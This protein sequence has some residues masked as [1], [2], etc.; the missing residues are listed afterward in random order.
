VQAPASPNFRAPR[1]SSTFAEKRQV[2]SA[3]ACAVP[4]RV[5]TS[6]PAPH[7]PQPNPSALCRAPVSRSDRS[8]RG[9][10]PTARVPA[11]AKCWPVARRAEEICGASLPV[12]PTHALVLRDS[13]RSDSGGQR[14]G[15]SV[16]SPPRSGR[17]FAPGFALRLAHGRPSVGRLGISRE[18][19]GSDCRSVLAAACRRLLISAGSRATR[20]MRSCWTSARS[21]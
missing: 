7:E 14:A 19:M 12:A 8:H 2:R 21:W 17:L 11:S 1:A 15:P 3:R 5:P 13:R 10:G 18:A 6:A 16:R 4:S 20:S 9:R